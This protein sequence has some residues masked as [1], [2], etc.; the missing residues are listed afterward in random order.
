M[1]DF[2]CFGDVI[3]YGGVVIMVLKLMCFD[4]RYVVCKGDEVMC[5]KYDICFNFIIEGDEIML[6]DGVL[7]V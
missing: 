2:I 1:I 4:G 3:D 5:L 7:V 6:D